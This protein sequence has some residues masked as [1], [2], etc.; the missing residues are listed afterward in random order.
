MIP[1]VF[2]VVGRHT[3]KAGADLRRLD[4]SFVQNNN[5][6]GSF[7]FDNAFTAANPNTASTD[8]TGVGFASFLLGYGSG[9]AADVLANTVGYQYLLGANFGDT[10]HLSPRRTFYVRI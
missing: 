6:G 4:Q 2:K 3:F 5:P 1:S 8:G 9:G 10:I 7:S